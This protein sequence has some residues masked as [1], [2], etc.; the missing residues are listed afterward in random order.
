MADYPGMYAGED[1]WINDI[2][3]NSVDSNGCRWIVSDI[4][5]W[6]GLPDAEV[7]EDRRPFAED[8][9]YYVA[10][11]YGARNITVTGHIVPHGENPAGV[12]FTVAA[13]D[14]LNRTLNMVRQTGV[15]RVDE[16]G[17]AKSARVQIISRPITR[18]AKMNDDLLFTVEFR[19]SDPRKYGIV[20]TVVETALPG[21]GSGRTYNKE[22][23]YTYGNNSSYGV[24]NVQNAGSY[25]TY[26]TFRIEGPVLNPSIE[27]LE[28]GSTLYFDI[29]LMAGEYLT[30]DLRTKSV[31]LNGLANRRTTMTNR[32]QWFTIA[33][34]SNTIRFS[35][36]QSPSARPY[37]PTRVNYAEVPMANAGNTTVGWTTN[38]G[39]GVTGAGTYTLISGAIDGPLGITTYRRKTWTTASTTADGTGFEVRGAAG[40]FSATPN[41]PITAS[42]YIRSSLAGRQVQARIAWHRGSTTLSTTDGT[43]VLTSGTG[44]TRISVEGIAPAGTDS[45]RVLLDV[46][47]DSPLF[48]VGHTLDAT[49]LLIER[50]TVVG[51]VLRTNLV[52]NPRVATANG[53]MVYGGVGG[54]ATPTTVATGGPDGGP[55]R[56][57]T[58]TVAG[59]GDGIAYQPTTDPLVTAGST[60]TFS[61]YGR[62]SV[63][64]NM[65]AQIFW[66]NDVG[67]V[68]GNSAG[69]TTAVAA[70]TWVRHS[71]TGTAPAGAVRVRLDIRFASPAP[72]GSTRDAS[73]Y[74]F[75]EGSTLNPYFDGSYFGATWAGTADASSS[76]LRSTQSATLDTYFDGS[77]QGAVW[78]GTV[79]GSTSTRAE[80][81]EI[82]SAML[83]LTYRSAW[84]E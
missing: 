13:R 19:A 65:F 60:Y 84:I 76:L 62:T 38:R 1:V 7:P 46:R 22:F 23:S 80:Q 69:T 2:P 55:F 45:F 20:D 56:R 17:A 34:G 29:S 41:T 78:D 8:G 12:P 52:G 32:S 39:F 11:R 14:S 24:L 81:L 35:G 31:I 59:N 82:P 42:G 75:E 18:F 3:L 6:W 43:S 66:L 72:V 68:I 50:G 67:T 40:Y 36:T 21:S 53:W 25:E 61:G 16:P 37:T 28:S 27:H 74:L 26:G 57:G 10:G 9:N 47:T 73:L 77:S 30:V 4:E 71:V 54:T 58:W 33:P 83:Y 63:A 49:G 51:N 5:G 44:W 70:N 15:L 48:S 79:N 64:Q